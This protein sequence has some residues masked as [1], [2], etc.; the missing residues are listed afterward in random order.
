MLYENANHCHVQQIFICIQ[1]KKSHSFLTSC[2]SAWEFSFSSS[3]QHNLITHFLYFFAA[4]MK[5]VNLAKKILC[6]NYFI[7][8]FSLSWDVVWLDGTKRSLLMFINFLLCE[9][10]FEKSL[11]K[12]FASLVMSMIFRRLFK[13]FVQKTNL[14]KIR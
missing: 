1:F 7:N 4:M 13:F 12:I 3:A 11:I 14:K 9:N 2:R 8:S 10:Y 5:M 6:F